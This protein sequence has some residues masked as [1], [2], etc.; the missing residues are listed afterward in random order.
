MEHWRLFACRHI[1]N[2]E[3]AWQIT[4]TVSSKTFYVC[5]ACKIKYLRFKGFIVS[6]IPEWITERHDKRKEILKVPF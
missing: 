3:M 5:G 4:D 2:Q 6:K 1:W